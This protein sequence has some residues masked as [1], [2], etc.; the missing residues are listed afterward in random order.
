MADFGGMTALERLLIRSVDAGTVPGAVA[1]LDR[2]GVPVET[3]AVGRSAPDGPPIAADAVFRIMSMTKAVTAVATLRFVESGALALDDSVETWLPE[4][5]DRR[6]LVHP[7]AP[8]ADTVPATTPIT[9]RH[10]L[11]NTSGYGSVMTD[12]PLGRAMIAGGTETGPAPLGLGADDWLAALAALPL[13]F[14][15]GSGW[16]Y[17]H[18]FGILGILLSRLVGRP[19]GDHLRDDLF[20]PLDMPDTGFWASAAAAARLPGAYRRG[21]AGLIETHPPAGGFWSVAPPFDVSHG[22]LVSTA[23][24]YH[25][26]LR[27]LQD[28]ELITEHHRGLMT[29]DRVPPSAK[30]PDSFFPGFWDG[31][32]WGFG[33]GVQTAGSH[34]GSYGWSGGLGTDF[35]VTAGGAIGILLTQ[36]EMDGQMMPLLGEF[37]EVVGT[38]PPSPSGE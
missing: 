34:A 1:V 4:L 5:R 36:V 31:M 26:F 25:R 24:D 33:V 30:A 9:V 19:L 27:A 3:V 14:A 18:S 16:R 7:D 23:A 20:V 32:G 12:S 17:H 38:V 37:Q 10:L 15:P 8:L 35:V 13:A 29:T 28:G 11:T 22:E 2:P 21:E 6:V